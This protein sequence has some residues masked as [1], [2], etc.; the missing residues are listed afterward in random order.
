MAMPRPLTLRARG[1]LRTVLEGGPHHGI[2]PQERRLVRMLHRATILAIALLPM[3]GLLYAHVAGGVL[4]WTY[5]AAAAAFALNLALLERHADP[6]RA[7]SAAVWILYALL[8]PSFWWLGGM[9][10]VVFAWVLVL[11]IAGTIVAERR[12]TQLWTGIGVATSVAFWA[13][14]Y[15]GVQL[16]NNVQETAGLVSLASTLAAFAVVAMLMRIW[17]ELQGAL[18]RDLAAGLADAKRE[19]EHVALLRDTSA[20][21]NA[22][23]RFETVAPYCLARICEST[24]VSAARLWM[25][26]SEGPDTLVPFAEHQAP[27]AALALPAPDFARGWIGDARSSRVVDLGESPSAPH[28]LLVQPIAEDRV[29]GALELHVAKSDRSPDEILALVAHVATQLAHV[30]ARESTQSAIEKLAYRDEVSGLPNRH[31]FALQLDAS[32]KRAAHEGTATALLFVDLNGFKRVNDSLGH[33]AGDEL[34]RKVAL[35]IG[36]AIRYSDHLWRTGAHPVARFG[37]DEFTLLLVDLA[38][39]R[40]AEIAAQRILD[41]LERPVKIGDQEIVI[42]ASIGIALFPSDARDP[43]ELIRLADRAMYRAKQRGVSS[44]ERHRGD[45]R[46]GRYRVQIERDLRAAL[47]Q[48]GLEVHYQPI[49]GARDGGLVGAEALLR[50][51]HPE[52]GEISPADFVPIAEHSGLIDRMGRF[53]LDEVCKTAAA[54]GARAPAGFRIAANVSARQLM[55]PIH[56]HLA[57]AL[58]QHRCDPQHVEL[59]LTETALL[60]GSAGVEQ[61]LRAISGLGVRLVLDDF[62]TGYSSLAFLKQFPIHKVKIER[63]FVA[64]LPGEGGDV[65]ITLAI[66][67]MAHTLGL[68]VVAEGVED[69]AQQ[70][71][72]ALRGCDHL[73]GYLLGRPLP[74]AAFA[75]R[76]LR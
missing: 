38:G 28:F 73:Q 16:P 56:E 53:A 21:S 54:W 42:G 74:A 60:V 37:G 13:L 50:W 68:V 20:A 31:A 8:L 58:A 71:F 64:G 10:S 12:A 46:D 2:D 30:A 32:L 41:G 17:L 47:D 44:W 51:N 55:S 63:G 39:P 27:N 61:R 65:A 24:Q 45:E 22:G 40:G 19:A 11:P 59:E 35:R 66:I 70:E 5:L 62:G 48:G 69:E 23:R 6:H 72:L 67:A 9:N 34:L 26:S 33:A 25:A 75:E 29:I 52:R 18:E 7:G 49:L 15:A 4:L 1:L 76:W 3:L 14:P 43:N 57:E 36:S